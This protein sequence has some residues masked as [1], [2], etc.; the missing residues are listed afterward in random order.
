MESKE[1][2][3]VQPGITQPEATLREVQAKLRVRS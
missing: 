3:S 1:R 2:V